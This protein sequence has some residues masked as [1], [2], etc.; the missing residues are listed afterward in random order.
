MYLASGHSHTDNVFS[1][2]WCFGRKFRN[3]TLP[4][5][6]RFRNCMR[7]YWVSL[8]NELS[9]ER[10]DVVTIIMT[11]L[12]KCHTL[13]NMDQYNFVTLTWDDIGKYF[14]K[15]L[16]NKTSKNGSELLWLSLLLLLCQVTQ[17]V[18]WTFSV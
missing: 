4:V 14:P 2:I 18:T 10:S 12:N 16:W 6:S 5:I 11:Y 17:N 7:E 8:F 15:C 3:I 1:F 9:P 13:Y